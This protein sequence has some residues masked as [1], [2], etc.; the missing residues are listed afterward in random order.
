[1]VQMSQYRM[2]RISRAN[3]NWWW[4]LWTCLLFWGVVLPTDAFAGLSAPQ[5]TFAISADGK[6]ILVILSTLIEYDKNS[7]ATLPD[8]RLIN[9]HDTFAKSGAYDANTLEPIWQVD[10]YSFNWDILWSD[11]FRHVVRLNEKGIDS[12]WAIA[13]YDNG[14]EIKSYDCGTLLTQ[15]KDYSYFEFTSGNWHTVWY[16]NYELSADHSRFLLSTAKRQKR[17]YGKKIDLG[18]QEFYEFDLA[19]NTIVSQRA[20]GGW[21][22]A[23]YAAVPLAFAVLLLL[24]ILARICWPFRNRTLHARS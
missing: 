21:K 4:L 16:S 9:L 11:D 7:S 8:G 5:S 15:M 12:D 3:N 20:E 14:K 24:G 6:R 19:T 22:I 18:F 1:M 10:W 23:A 13:F 2:L 17:F